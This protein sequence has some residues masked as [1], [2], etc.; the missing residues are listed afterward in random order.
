MARRK[1]VPIETFDNQVLYDTRRNYPSLDCLTKEQL[2]AVDNRIRR[3]MDL[4]NNAKTSF[5]VIDYISKWISGRL[6]FKEKNISML[7]DDLKKKKYFFKDPW[8]RASMIIIKE[9]TN[10]LTEGFNMIVAHSDS[11]CLRVKPRP[12]K[13]EWAQDEVYNH[14]GVRLSAIPHGGI[15]PHQWVGQQVNLIGYTVGKDGK[16]IDIKEPIPGV[17][18]DCSAHVDYRSDEQVN[19]AFA[20]EKSLEI[21]TGHSD[22]RETLSRLDLSNLDDFAQTKLYAVPTNN[23]LAIDEYNW[24]LLVAYGH[25]DRA[26]V[27][28]AVDALV[29]ARN[30]KYTGII[31]ITDGEETGENA[32]SGAKGP[33]LDSV[34]DYVLEEQVKKYGLNVSDRD[35]RLMLQRS[36]LIFGDVDIAPYG[37]DAENMDVKGAP[38]LGFGVYIASDASQVSNPNFIRKLRNLALFG[39]GKNQNI[40]HQISGIGYDQD[41]EEVWHYDAG[42]KEGLVSKIGQW[43]WAGIPCASVHSHN[44][45]ICPGDELAAFKFYKRFFESDVS[46]DGE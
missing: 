41:R 6:S 21:I 46:M 1:Q 27:F 16:R 28:S 45:I 13:I 2:S 34:L 20:P 39:Q 25:D 17:V 31:W 26:C 8:E 38:K 44:E 7:Y 5:Q 29:R 37:Y 9:G 3:L 12:V 23:A 24:R 35:R 32:P 10:P 30:L 18:G 19:E 33:F 4:E 11:P 22:V 43:S 42:G 40:C 15:S 14:L 36:S